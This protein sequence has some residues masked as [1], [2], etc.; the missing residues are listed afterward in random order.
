MKLTLRTLLISAILCIQIYTLKA[1]STANY[2]FTNGSNGSFFDINSG[3]TTLIG[4]GLDGLNFGVLSPTSPI[5]FRFYYMS[6]PYDEFTV[7]EDGVLRLGASTSGVAIPPSLSSS[8]PRLIIFGCDMSTGTNGKVHY[9]LTGA[10]PNRVLVVEWKNSNII[11]SDIPAPGSS[12][13]QI[14]L[15]ENSGKIEYVYGFMNVESRGA[16]N[17]WSDIGFTN[18]TS[19]NLVLSKS[20]NFT[21]T[22]VNRNY[23]FARS[24]G[25]WDMPPA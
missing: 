16:Q 4:P 17:S 9:K 11:Y 25:D 2:S 7:T 12:S 18:G 22:D 23:L 8:E 14:R 19:N 5:G 15:Y 3:S 24:S 6:H 1:Q 21:G 13:F 20:V 10:E